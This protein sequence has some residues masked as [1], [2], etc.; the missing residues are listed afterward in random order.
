MGLLK[1]NINSFFNINNIFSCQ[2]F[3]YKK[4]VTETDRQFWEIV[5]STYLPSVLREN[6]SV[7]DS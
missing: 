5:H 6:Y 1:G 7:A 2:T 4:V 3:L